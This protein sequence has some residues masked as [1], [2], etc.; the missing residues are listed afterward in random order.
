MHR[1]FAPYIS[2][3]VYLLF[4]LVYLDDV[5]IMSK[6]PEE[7]LTHL[8]LVLEVVEKQQLPV[9]EGR[10]EIISCDLVTGL[11]RTAQGHNAILVFADRLTKYAHLVPTQESLIEK[12]FAHLFV[13]HK[14]VNHGM[15]KTIISDR[16]SQWINKFWQHV[17]HSLGVTHLMST[18]YHPEK[19]GQTERMSR[20]MKEILFM[21]APT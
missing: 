14:F 7:H 12:G 4:V 8:R 15:P 10:W 11:S 6:S 2:N 18:A 20:I 17:C 5:L 19:D 16:G 9:P 3:L 21:Q 13:Q 1:I